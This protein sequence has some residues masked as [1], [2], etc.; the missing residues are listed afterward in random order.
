MD[1]PGRE[2]GGQGRGD[3]RMGSF[4]N[5]IRGPEEEEEGGDE[6]EVEDED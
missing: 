4:F 6:N 3:R 5:R 2:A 1:C